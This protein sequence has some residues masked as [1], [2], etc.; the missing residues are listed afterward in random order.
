MLFWQLV[1]LKLAAICFLKF[2]LAKED[3]DVLVVTEEASS[4]VLEQDDLLGN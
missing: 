3:A 2:D 1:V 4:T